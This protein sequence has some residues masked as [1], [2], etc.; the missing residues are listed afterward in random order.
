MLPTSINDF[1]QY[2]SLSN[3]PSRDNLLLTLAQ[4]PGTTPC[5]LQK[6][7]ELDWPT[8]K[9]ISED[10]VMSIYTLTLIRKTYCQRNR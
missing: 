9:V 4:A 7:G 5:N 1:S 8:S 3:D 10:A 2:F 6:I